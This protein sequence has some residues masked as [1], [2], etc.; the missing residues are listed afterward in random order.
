MDSNSIHGGEENRI[1]KYAYVSKAETKYPVH[2][3]ATAE[4]LIA[5]SRVRFHPTLDE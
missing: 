2:P 3:L 5:Y 1:G 4:A